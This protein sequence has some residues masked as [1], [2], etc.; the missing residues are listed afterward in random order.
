MTPE[1][2]ALLTTVCGY[3]TGPDCGHCAD[4]YRHKSRRKGWTDQQITADI[5]L[6]RDNYPA[7]YWRQVDAAV[8][9]G[10]MPATAHHSVPRPSEVA[11]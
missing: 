4:T 1:L 11:S 3:H 5:L 6:Y 2:R 7:W 8:A 10:R 9:A